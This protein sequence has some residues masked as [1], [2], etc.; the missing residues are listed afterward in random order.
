MSIAVT[1]RS[2]LRTVTGSW[3]SRIYLAAVTSVLA[4]AHVDAA[5]VAQADSSFAGIHSIAATAPLS[6]VLLLSGAFEVLPF[7]LLIAACALVNAYLLGLAAR[8]IAARH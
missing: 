7:S 3:A 6:V 5:F 4:W 8:R 2:V 1:S